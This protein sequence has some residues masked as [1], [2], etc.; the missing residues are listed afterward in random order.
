MSDH[1]YCPNCGTKLDI[2]VKYCS[3]CGSSVSPVSRVTDDDTGFKKLSDMVGSAIELGGAAAALKYVPEERRKHYREV[4]EE[5]FSLLDSALMLI[6]RRLKDIL[7]IAESDKARFADELKRLDNIEE[8]EQLERD[9]RLCR[10]LRIASR[11]MDSLQAELKDRIS[12]KDRETLRYLIQIVLREG[13]GSLAQFISSSLYSLS[14][15]LNAA[16]EPSEVYAR[17]VEAVRKTRDSLLEE[18][19]KLVQAQMRFFEII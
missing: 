7:L 15:K 14:N 18:R 12:I 17:A 10:S 13:E 9:V 16:G 6:V 2:G 8:W 5:T 19:N 3:E 4:I 1:Q 11:E